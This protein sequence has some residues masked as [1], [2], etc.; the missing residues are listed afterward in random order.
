M[1]KVKNAP[2]KY[3]IGVV[4]FPPVADLGKFAG[5]IQA[6]L[7]DEYPFGSNPKF[8]E[9]S[10]RID[11]KGVDVKPQEVSLW[12]FLNADHT[13]GII[14]NQGL[15]G[16][17]T[18]AYDNHEDFLGRLLRVVEVAKNLE[19]NPLRFVE[20]IALR[21]V[22]LIVPNEGEVLSDYMQAKLPSDIGIDGLTMNDGVNV[23]GMKSSVGNLRL[24]VFLNPKTVIPTDLLSPLMTESGWTWELPE[25]DFVTIDTDHATVYAPP[26]EMEKVDI[27]EHMFSL[28]KPISDIFKKIATQHAMAVWGLE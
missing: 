27:R 16:L 5:A 4:R 1:E 6:A 17:H 15:V 19:G 10:I 2:V 13:C 21:Y 25:R 7:G 3:V 20:A 18:V 11:E 9:F 14:V 22:D 28:R 12:Q 8:T 24:Q 26:I 23:L